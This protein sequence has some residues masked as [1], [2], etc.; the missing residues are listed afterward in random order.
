MQQA[1][2][3]DFIEQWQII[4]HQTKRAAFDAKAKTLRETH[5]AQH[6]RGIIHKAKC[7]QN[8]NFAILQIRQATP[9]VK[10][11]AKMRAIQL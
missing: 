2:A 8:A 10:Q 7:V 5:R 6:A 9:E 1:R 11:S 4:F 3:T